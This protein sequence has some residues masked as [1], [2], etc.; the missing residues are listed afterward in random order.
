MQTLGVSDFGIFS[1]LAGVVAMLTFITNSLVGATQR[2]VSYY[3]GKGIMEELVKVFNNSLLVHILLAF[4]FFLGLE[5]IGPFLFDGFL[6]IPSDRLQAAY[7]IYHIVIAILIVTL[8]SSPYHALLISHE[9]IVYISIT[10]VL[11]AILRVIFVI[12]MTLVSQDKLIFYASIM[13]AT[14]LFGFLAM[15]AYTMIKYEECILPTV[16]L[17][18]KKILKSL[19]SYSGWTIY[20]TGCYVGQRQGIAIVINKLLGTTAN[21]AYGIAFQVAGYTSALS[22]AVVN[23]IKPQIVKAEGGGER[24]KAMWLSYINSKISYFLTS[25][26]CIPFSFEIDSILKIWLTSVP[27]YA[28]TFCIMSMV[29]LM[30]DA[31]TT[32]LGTMNSAIGNISKYCLVMGTPKLLTLP[33]AYILLKLGFPILYLVLLY[34]IV[35]FVMAMYR[36]PYLSNEAGLNVSS[37]L[38]D[39]LCMEIIPTIVCVVVCVIMTHII[40]FEYRFILTTAISGGI[41][42][43]SIYFWGLTRNERFIINDIVKTIYFKIRR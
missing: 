23:A 8:L 29:A 19:L 42:L 1:L 33:V 21:A 24:N 34:I 9:N 41:F 3:Q 31:T 17:A 40:H 14:E 38:K 32:G 30:C 10:Q 16:R 22:G 4:L 36:I 20:S 35:E 18:D 7:T 37:F 6:N 27:E 2:F 25:L 26:I 43:L 12:V 5:M 13:F 28:G 39:V 11:V 15:F